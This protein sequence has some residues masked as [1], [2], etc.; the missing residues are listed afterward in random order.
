MEQWLHNFA[1]IVDFFVPHKEA[2]MPDSFMSFF[3]Q[4][5]FGME[6]MKLPYATNIQ[7]QESRRNAYL[8]SMNLVKQQHEI[9]WKTTKGFFQ[10]FMSNAQHDAFSQM[11][12]KLGHGVE[13]LFQPGPRYLLELH[14]TRLQEEKG[15]L[16]FLDFMTKP[17]PNQKFETAYDDTNVLLDLP[18]LRLIDISRNDIEHK[19]KNYVV[20]FAP[21][22][23]HHSNIAERVALHM[24]DGGLTRTAIV[25]QK[26]SEEIPLFIDGKE[27]SE[28]FEGQVK[29]YVQVLEHLTA[30]T[31]KPPH[32]VGVCQPGPLLAA[33]L[34]MNPEL[35]KTFGTAGSP[36]DTEGESAV[37][38]DFSRMMGPNYIDVLLTLFGRTIGSE[39]PGKGRK[40]YNGSAH[41]LGFYMMGAGQHYDNFKKL[42]ADLKS[43]DQES[44]KRQM[45]FYEWYHT[46]HHFP[47]EFIR[48]TYKKVFVKNQLARGE[49]TI[50][51]R[52]IG[53]K[54]YPGSVPIWAIGGTNDNIAPPG[55]ALGHLDLIDSVKEED[56]LVQLCEAGHMGLFRS[57]RILKKNYGKIIDFMLSHSDIENRKSL[58]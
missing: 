30:M 4:L 53:I 13:E 44:A 23:G 41:V 54:D 39:Y 27:H 45:E 55:Q 12:E 17:P 48:D 49:L 21:R 1:V 2:N 8:S 46:V 40:V 57:S 51:E 36:M 16:Q 32:L 33:T 3:P 37:L 35:G 9:A 52:T 15:T 47:A 38:T 20:V 24:R 56:K 29:Q 7:V 28:G 5:T 26:C 22:A 58:N 10:L 6:A 34:I 25:E 50:G 14:Q 18:S 31:G 19:V 11:T 42:L 43:G